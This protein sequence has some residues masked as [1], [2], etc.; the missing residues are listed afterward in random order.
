[1]S[2]RDKERYYWLKL[3]KDFFTRPEISVLEAMPNGKDY[4]LF[5]LKLMLQSVDRAGS[6]RLTDTIPYSEATLASVTHTNVGVVRAAIQ[7]LTEFGMVEILDD[8]TLF[9]TEVA[10]ILDSET[11]A[12]KRKREQRNGPGDNVPR[13]SPG[14]PPDIEI[15]LDTEKEKEGETDGRGLDSRHAEKGANRWGIRYDN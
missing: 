14:C 13:L 4:V 5:Y 12:A 11:F 2:T 1:M 8:K 9:M 6:L 7:I 10:A 3:R 15:E